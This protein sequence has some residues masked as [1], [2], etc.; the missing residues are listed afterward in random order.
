MSTPFKMKG[1]NFK[2]SPMKDKKGYSKEAKN[3]LKVVP[4]KEAYDKLSEKDKKGFN[5]AAKKAG[6]PM[7]TKKLFTPAFV[8]YLGGTESEAVKTLIGNFDLKIKGKRDI[9]E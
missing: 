9:T 8:N 7:E 5:E 1:M 2:S 3:L 6:L 4:N